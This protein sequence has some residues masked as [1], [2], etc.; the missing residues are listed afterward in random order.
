MTAGDIDKILSQGEGLKVE[1]KSAS[2]S[3]PGS[4]Y[5]TV[6]SFSNTDG[7]S[8]YLGINDNG[9]VEGVNPAL[10]AKL[11]K[12]IV[13][14]LNSIDCINPPVYVQ[15]VS[16]SHPDGLIIAVQIPS[17]SQVHDHKGIIYIREF[18][19]DIDI[20][21][22]QSKVSDL[23]LQKRTYFTES[24]I[25]PALAMSDLD[26]DLFQ[27]ARDIIRGN[28]SDH[29]WVRTGDEQMLRES[30]LLRKDFQ[31]GA[32]GLTLAAALIFGKDST[33]QSLLPAYKVEA[34]VRRENK[35]RWD[36]R[37]DPP[38]RTN[39]IDTYLKLKEFVFKHLPEKFFTEDGQRVDLRDRIFRE[40]V[41][42]LIV[43]RE[44]TSALSSEL[45]IYEN[46]VVT[47]NPNR[48]L[49]HGP[50]DLNSFNP[51]PKNPNIRKFFN[52][53]GWTDEIGSGVR[54]TAK[55]L[56][57]YV[58]GASPVFIENNIFKS[59]IPTVSVQPYVFADNI[60][61]WLELDE[62]ILIHLDKGLRNFSLNPSLAFKEWNDVLLYLVPTWN[63]KGT[64]L[65]ELDWPKKQV[66][67]ANAI[68]KVPTW[69]EKS[70]DLLHKKV[71][72][73]I[74]IL[75]ICCEA[76]SLDLIMKTLNYKNR[77]TFRD[78]YLTPLEQTQLLIKTNPENPN[79]PE[80]KYVITEAGKL[81]L[82]GIDI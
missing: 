81:F 71:R 45:I 14:A 32:E 2:N 73:I 55:Y 21:D 35:D 10:S 78:N 72:Y 66:L 69:E 1:F 79:D 12:D 75:F 56:P 11:Q 48:A 39:L 51:Y 34:M 37:I 59:V 54:N 26:T 46:E 22:N 24:Q 9:I 67:N 52:S 57:F 62:N 38:L 8:I 25:Y 31:T 28:R 16:I 4:F 23:Y 15:P 44:Y 7:G 70:A 42:N 13:S 30:V 68:K 58:S 60:I 76:A 29:P 33:I 74:S 36:D 61:K 47:T 63:Q 40:V 20:T 17:S 80:Q 77:K 3:I 65:A 43:H 41:G 53:F 18:E 5:E 82:G 50:L 6:V 27:K 49:F 64:N 19:S